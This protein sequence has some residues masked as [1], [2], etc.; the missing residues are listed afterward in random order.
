MIIHPK[1]NLEDLIIKQLRREAEI[2][3]PALSAGLAQELNGIPVA[4]RRE[5]G[6]VAFQH[7]SDNDSDMR[8]VGLILHSDPAF[9]ALQ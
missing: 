4:K 6:P 2:V 9:S 5:I 7:S 8:R 3:Q 1:E